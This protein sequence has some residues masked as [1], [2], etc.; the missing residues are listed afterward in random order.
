MAWEVLHGE[1]HSK[2]GF[3][4]MPAHV[5]AKDLDLTSWTGCTRFFLLIQW[6]PI[7]HIRRCHPVL[8]VNDLRQPSS[9]SWLRCEMPQSQAKLIMT[10]NRVT[11]IN[12]VLDLDFDPSHGISRKKHFAGAA[13]VA[14]RYHQQCWA[15]RAWK[16][17]KLCQRSRGFGVQSGKAMEIIKLTHVSHP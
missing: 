8:W 4:K 5:F 9:V 2:I 10:K 15:T 12:F 17:R 13:S 6:I 14:M 1:K 16:H 11:G 7:N 3:F